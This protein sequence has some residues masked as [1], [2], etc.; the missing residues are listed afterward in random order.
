MA[1]AVLAMLGLPGLATANQGS[2][3]V[4][5]VQNLDGVQSLYRVWLTWPQ[6]MLTT[7][8]G[9]AW[10]F[11]TGQAGT[12]DAPYKLFVSRFDPINARW[13]IAQP[14]PG[15][16]LQFGVAGAVDANGRAHVIFTDRSADDPAVFGQLLYTRD[17]G[18]GTWTTPVAISP[19]EKAGHQLAGSI[20]VDANGVV[21][22]VWQDQ[23]YASDEQRAASPANADILAC[24]VTG[25]GVC[26]Y[27][28]F[29]LSVPAAEGEI[30]NRP[31]IATDGER[32]VAV[33]STYAGT[34]NEL[35][36]SATQIS[37]A[38]RPL[39]QGSGWTAP[40]AMAFP[41]GA[42]IGGRLVDIASDPTGGVSLAF[43]RRTD[44]TQLY[45]TRLAAGTD[46]WAAPI[47]LGD[48]VRGAFPSIVVGADG[49][50]Y[51]AYN[52]GNAQSVTVAGQKIPA[53]A[54]TASR[55]TE[56]STAEFGRKGQPVIDIDNSGRV[57]VM[58][59]FEPLLTG[60]LP[61]EQI[62]NEIRVERGVSFFDEVAPDAQ[63]LPPPPAASP[64]A[65]PAAVEA[66]PAP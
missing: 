10:V 22:I 39:E 9:G 30:G 4:I 51:V 26:A 12:I 31:Q 42:A 57:W 1:L 16:D 28:P 21:H 27:E 8:D 23:R 25:D 46:L 40:Q 49:T 58:Y 36:Q 41:E 14:V 65:S 38:A 17:N 61:A 62:P 2:Y 52:R 50:T 32:V 53:G 5:R 20:V 43:G 19:N 66:T 47:L 63:L 37:W 45:L 55:E 44:Y 11:F 29:R 59:V 34:S 6:M 54:T 13:T 18:D 33:W 35:L 48:G 56:I 15:G 3:D 64:E 7:P 24:E 60:E